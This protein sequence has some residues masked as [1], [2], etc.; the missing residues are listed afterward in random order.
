MTTVIAATTDAPAEVSAAERLTALEAAA[1]PLTARLLEITEELTSL[2]PGGGT[3]DDELAARRKVADL[4]M[5]QEVVQSRL[6]PLEAQM[7]P[8]R[9]EVRDAAKRDANFQFES[10]VLEAVE[11]IESVA[12]KLLSD[13]E[14]LR[15]QLDAGRRSSHRQSMRMQRVL[16][17]LLGTIARASNTIRGGVR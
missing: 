3:I 13:A 4:Q 2:V 12:A 5:E 6:A 11:G 7:I 9:A 10:D 16:N 15:G 8:L 1:R 17:D 14:V